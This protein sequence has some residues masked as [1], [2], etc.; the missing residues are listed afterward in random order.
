MLW[1]ADA[2]NLDQSQILSFGKELTN[3]ISDRSKLKAITG[4]KSNDSKY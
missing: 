1:S 3:E 2:I 4:T